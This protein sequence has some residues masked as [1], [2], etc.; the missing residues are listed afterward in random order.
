L[1]DPWLVSAMAVLAP[2]RVEILRAFSLSTTADQL[3]GLHRVQLCLGGWW[4]VIAVD[5]YIPCVPRTTTPFGARCRS[6]RDV[7]APLLEKAMAKAYGSYLS[8]IGGDPLE[9]IA[10]IAGAAAERL[11]WRAKDAVAF[12]TLLRAHRREMCVLVTAPEPTT[13]AATA[14]TKDAS[15]SSVLVPNAAST[16]ANPAT[17][18]DSSTTDVAHGAQP[19]HR[20]TVMGF[21]P[22]HAYLLLAAVHCDEFRLCLVS[23]PEGA[24]D[25]NGAWSPKS[26]KWQRH[27]A[28]RAACDEAERGVAVSVAGGVWIEWRDVAFNFA[29]AGIVSLRPDWLDVRI[30]NRFNGVRPQW[31]MELSVRRPTTVII[32]VHQRDRRSLPPNDPERGYSA[33]LITV[34]ACSD[35]GVW[36]AVEQSHGGTFWR[37][38]DVNLE[39]QLTPRD[40]AYYII[41]RRYTE[42]RSKDVTVSLQIEH[43][44]AVVAALKQPTEEAMNSVRYSPVWKFDPLPCPA[45]HPMPEMQVDRRPAGNLEW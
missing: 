40:R 3:A 10:D 20:V 6:P 26:E 39:V 9:A 18:A 35:A 1:D 44:D 30:A 38:R 32:G 5:S 28:V 21:K 14:A 37:G 25:W 23:N 45:V 8:L 27:P 42:E 2:R 31:I 29:G 24:A 16:S 34:V 43:K 41:P 12:G 17:T 11:D 7:W 33:F 22:G 4:C 15:A 13:A 36:D 19:H